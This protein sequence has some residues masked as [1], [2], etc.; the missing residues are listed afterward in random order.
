M[1]FG[2]VTDRS[3]DGG[4][5]EEE[6]NGMVLAV[7]EGLPPTMD[8]S[9]STFHD[10]CQDSLALLTPAAAVDTASTATQLR[11][12]RQSK[13]HI[14][15]TRSFSHAALLVEDQVEPHQAMQPN[16]VGRAA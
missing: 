10:F 8:Y 9:D 5:E 4:E 3:G 16:R 14:L 11:R 13:N 1:R 6:E 12:K 2:T 7:T 15:L